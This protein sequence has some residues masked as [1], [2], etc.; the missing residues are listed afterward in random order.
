MFELSQP[1]VTDRISKCMHSSGVSY[2]VALGAFS[3][4]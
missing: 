4:S 3:A 2:E 1:H